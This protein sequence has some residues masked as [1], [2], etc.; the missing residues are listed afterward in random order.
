MSFVEREKEGGYEDMIYMRMFH[1]RYYQKFFALASSRIWI[2]P[3][4]NTNAVS[5]LEIV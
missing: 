2:I 1:I 3:S 5:D 4:E